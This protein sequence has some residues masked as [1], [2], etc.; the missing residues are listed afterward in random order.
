MS[1]HSSFH[2][3]LLLLHVSSPQKTSIT[4]KCHSKEHCAECHFSFS[5]RSDENAD[6]SF[7][8]KMEFEDVKTDSIWSLFY[9]N[10]KDATVEG[11]EIV[12]DQTISTTE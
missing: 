9:T 2:F 1:L 8:V 3:Y 10:K 7:T 12:T 6:A 11:T 5:C 4:W